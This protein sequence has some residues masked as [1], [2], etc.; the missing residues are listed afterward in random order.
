M[1]EDK[2]YWG[3]VVEADD[4]YFNPYA[5]G[6]GTCVDNEGHISYWIKF[7]MPYIEFVQAF[8]DD[9]AWFVGVTS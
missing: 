4:C 3:Q 6:M 5:K 8:P 9:A 7:K 1:L 2:H